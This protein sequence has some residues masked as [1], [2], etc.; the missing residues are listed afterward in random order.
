LF[1]RFLCWTMVILLPPALSASG[2]GGGM[3]YGRGTVWLNN[4][5]LARPSAIVPGDIIST[6][7]SSVASIVTAGANVIIQPQTDVTFE[8]NG[9]ELRHGT[10]VVSTSTSM[11]VHVGC[12]EAIPVANNWTEYQVTDV[13]GTVHVYANK[14]DVNVNE[15]AKNQQKTDSSQT[16]PQD[17]KIASRHA[18]VLE[19]QKTER[20][21]HCK[22]G[23]A[24]QQ[25]RWSITPDE[26]KA[27]GL[28][29]TVLLGLWLTNQGDDPVSPWQP[30]QS[31]ETCH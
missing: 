21:E 16:R 26:L 28:S 3:L 27:M 18:T 10:V 2:T 1:R 25:Y 5:P 29:A 12:I 8:T 4:D 23:G 14:L 24:L 20:N 30:C 19:G 22:A 15:T 11:R 6:Q 17:A 31:A 9:L 13:N 7:A